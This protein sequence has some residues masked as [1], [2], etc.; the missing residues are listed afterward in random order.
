MRIKRVEI[1]SFGKFKNFSMDF[2]DGF[3]AIFGK[4]E[5]GKSTIMAFICL[6]LYG[7]AG[8]ASRN[9]LTQNIRKK[10]LPWSGEKMAGDMEIEHK[11]RTY[12]IHKEF[13]ATAKTD[14]V[15][16]TD[17]ETGEKLNLPPDTEVGKY[18]L[19]IDYSSFDKSIFS[20]TSKSFAGEECSD[21]SVRLSNL[22]GS[23]DENISQKEA[24]GRIE[25]AM[26]DLIKKRS[27]GRLTLAEEKCEAYAAE[28]EMAEITEN[29][30]QALLAEYKKIEEELI[31]LQQQAEKGR[32]SIE[33][34]EKRRKAT[35]Y[36]TLAKLY[37]DVKS[38][39]KELEKALKGDKADEVLKNGED[40]KQALIFSSQKLEEMEIADD[41]NIVSEE[42][43]K[44]Y[45]LLKEEAYQGKRQNAPTNKLSLIA[46]WIF[47]LIVAFFTARVMD[48]V[49]VPAL[50][51]F[52]LAGLG[53]GVLLVRNKNKGKAEEKLSEFIN[54]KGLQSA[55]E[56]ERAYRRGI[57][58]LEKQKIYTRA[59]DD[60]REKRESFLLYIGKYKEVASENEANAFLDEVRALY[61][62]KTSIENEAKVYAATYGI[63]EGNQESFSVLAKKLREGI[64]KETEKIDWEATQKEIRS[65]NSRLLEIRGQLGSGG[66]NI[67]T[68]KKELLEAQEAAREMRE[69]YNNLALASEVLGEAEDEMRR[70]FAPRLNERAS[71]ILEVLT[72]GKYKKLSTDKAYEIE[73]KSEETAGYRNWQYL[74]RGTMAQSYLALRIAL[75]EMLSEDEKVPLFLDDVLTEYDEEREERTL[76]FLDNYAKNG[77]QIILFTCREINGAE[78][79]LQKDSNKN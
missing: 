1:A 48:T 51:V 3:N 18:F 45:F 17:V 26:D 8:N 42:D 25:S 50:V 32:L 31:Y 41:E 38:K 16:V 11:G 23:G 10:Y 35:V 53:T 65:K 5:D 73:I 69:Y 4:N 30:R 33:N 24:R 59:A 55:E 21:I 72:D 22:S 64:P 7:T 61:N 2:T 60:L 63:D 71:E 9:D 57:E 15:T 39:E 79:S 62:E 27:K 74:S 20:A 47:A 44:K 34:E 13:R 19:G 14:K 54:S 76:A 78:K 43:M 58:T 70:F 6:M 40:L 77:H 36:E 52:T 46:L 56:F 66:V 49:L 37:E 75:C 67:E 68:L 12:L 29:R 28:I